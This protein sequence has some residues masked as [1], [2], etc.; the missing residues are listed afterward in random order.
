M[1]YIYIYIYISFSFYTREYINLLFLFP[2]IKKEMLRTIAT[3]LKTST[4]NFNK[5]ELFTVY[6]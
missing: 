4:T 5:A 6:D 3:A 1:L 2:F